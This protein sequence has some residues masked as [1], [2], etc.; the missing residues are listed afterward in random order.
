MLA[1][2]R[3]SDACLGCAE[4]SGRDLR[5][6]DPQEACLFRTRPGSADMSRTME[7]TQT[8]LALACGRPETKRPARMAQPEGWPCQGTAQAASDRSILAVS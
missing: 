2:V 3:L 1:G 8:R 4:L 6:V 5:G 7:M